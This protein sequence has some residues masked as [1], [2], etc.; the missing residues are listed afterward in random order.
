M[1]RLF[2]LIVMAFGILWC[3]NNVDFTKIKNDT[4]KHIKNEKTI[5]AV[6]STRNE[7]QENDKNAFQEY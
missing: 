5:K 1:I 4:L 6:N 7:L 3:F 2:I